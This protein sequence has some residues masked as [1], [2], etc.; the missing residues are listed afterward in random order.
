MQ[1]R[2]HITTNTNQC[3]SSK[4]AVAVTKHKSKINQRADSKQSSGNQPFSTS[5]RC[6]ADSP[7]LQET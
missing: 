5:T 3:P 1:Q 2:K 6:A 4:R 7:C